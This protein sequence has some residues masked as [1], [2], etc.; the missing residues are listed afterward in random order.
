MEKKASA[1]VVITH[2]ER[3]HS[4]R[5]AVKGVFERALRRFVSSRVRP[6]VHSAA[7]AVHHYRASRFD[8]CFLSSSSGVEAAT[9]RALAPNRHSCVCTP[10]AHS[11]TEELAN[12]SRAGAQ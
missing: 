11:A 5:L 1:P 9:G 7:V 3:L 12:G 10:F 8:R 4:W 6:F 2:Q